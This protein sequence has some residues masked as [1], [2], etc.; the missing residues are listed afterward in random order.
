[1]SMG[2]VQ[3]NGSSPW[4]GSI[5]TG[6]ANRNLQWE[7]T[8]TKN[9]GFDYGLL[10][11]RLSGALNYYYNKTEDMLIT[12]KLAP[13]VGLNNPVM[14][15][16]KIR[17]SGFEMEINW[18]DKKGDWDYNVG[19]N[20]TTTSN[21]VLELSDPKQALYGDGLKWGTEHF[22][23]QTRVGEPI[24]SF[25]LYRADGIFQ[26]EA[27]VAAHVNADGDLLQPNARPGD[28]R[29]R[30]VNGDGQIDEDDKESCGSGMP[31][32]EANL[33][34]GFSYKGI[35]FSF[36]LGS[37]WGHKLYNGNR[38]FFEGM[39][40]GTNMLA[41]T[42]D[43][44]TTSNTNTSVPRAVLQDPNNNSRESDRFLENGN[45]VRLR[46]LQIGYTLPSTLLKKLFVDKL[47]L[48]VS[49]ENLFTITKYSGIDPEFSTEKILNTGVDKEI[50]PFTRSYIVGLQLTF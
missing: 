22:P 16:G 47:R 23:T 37:G 20:L 38:Y 25:Y 33:S 27:E 12:K 28:I 4:P 1:M 8:D 29:F 9:I 26:N 46:Q 7:T 21:K 41:S 39:S 36:L 19:L 43:A 49:G 5:A 11:G 3:G 42:L 14:N 13:S 30:D 32:L 17:N 40:S 50:Y 10:N 18:A 24:A 31:K 35:D 48:Y 45:F 2:A 34:A 6:L 44:W 15:V